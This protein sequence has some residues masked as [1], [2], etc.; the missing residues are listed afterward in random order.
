MIDWTVTHRICGLDELPRRR[1]D[2]RFTHI[3]SLLDPDWP[4]PEPLAHYPAERRMV[5]RF[6]DVIGPSLGMNPPE[7]AHVEALLAFG[8]SLSDPADLLVHC[9]AGISRSTAAM[10]A[11]LAQAHPLADEASVLRHIARI[12]PQAWPNSKMIAFADDLLGRKGRLNEALAAFY[13]RQL[14]AMPRLERDLRAGGRG[15]EVDMAHR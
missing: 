13:A 12:R 8:R 9:H 2:L 5:L 1:R 6:H 14:K 3:L 15:A 11:L 4:D 10:A 7:P